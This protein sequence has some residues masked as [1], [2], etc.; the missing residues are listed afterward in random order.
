MDSENIEFNLDFFCSPAD[1]VRQNRNYLLTEFLGEAPVYQ[2]PVNRTDNQ[3]HEQYHKVF[4]AIMVI[5]NIP[6]DLMTSWNNFD[7]H[8]HENKYD[9]KSFLIWQESFK[10]ILGC[11]DQYPLVP[12]GKMALEDLLLLLMHLRNKGHEINMEL[13]QLHYFDECFVQ[14]ATTISYANNDMP[15]K[16]FN[17]AIEYEDHFNEQYQQVVEHKLPW[18]A[19]ENRAIKNLQSLNGS[20]NSSLYKSKIKSILLNKYNE[21]NIIPIINKRC[22]DAPD[23]IGWW[24]YTHIFY[25]LYAR[26]LGIGKPP[27]KNK[28]SIYQGINQIPNLPGFD[29]SPTEG[30]IDNYHGNMKFSFLTFV[31]LIK[32]MQDNIYKVIEEDIR[33]SLINKSLMEYA[34]DG[35]SIHQRY[36]CISIFMKKLGHIVGQKI[37]IGQFF[38][39]NET[40]TDFKY[41]PNIEKLTIDFIIKE[42]DI[43]NVTINDDPKTKRKEFVAN[44]HIHKLSCA[45][46]R[47]IFSSA[48][49]KTLH[50]KIIRDPETQQEI[51]IILNSYFHPRQ[52]AEYLALLCILNTDLL[53]YIYASP[54]SPAF[55]LIQEEKG[56]NLTNLIK[57]LCDYIEYDIELTWNIF[58]GDDGLLSQL[59]HMH[60]RYILTKLFTIRCG[61]QYKDNYI[62]PTLQEYIKRLDLHDV[63][64]HI[65]NLSQSI[66]LSR[67]NILATLTREFNNDRDRACI[68]Y[69]KY[70]ISPSDKVIKSYNKIQLNTTIQCI[71][72]K[73]ISN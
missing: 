39:P 32:Y 18:N 37:N 66:Y 56:N 6:L 45:K 72:Y 2:Y 55:I 49:V 59:H 20:L 16:Y 12:E 7:N 63:S 5:N 40:S 54:Y 58:F 35:S 31:D 65:Y 17:D 33:D 41:L 11:I 25:A 13:I 61:D 44:L 23:I 24:H 19:L 57:I 27:N 53:Y 22:K 14:G 42:L 69:K 10:K 60:N 9:H 28:H 15:E 36:I 34:T 26:H 4:K 47:Q 71:A 1:Y 51:N 52:Q 38:Q 62:M 70:Q 29:I 21:Q 8:I 30:D 68:A 64:I 3:Y 50:N 48:K 73:K 67:I 43:V 46:T